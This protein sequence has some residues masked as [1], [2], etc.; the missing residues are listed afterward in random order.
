MTNFPSKSNLQ[1]SSVQHTHTHIHV[2]TL[3][4]YVPISAFFPGDLEALS[5]VGVKGGGGRHA[6]GGGY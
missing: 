1:C 5:T 3:Y 2:H 4:V 6:K